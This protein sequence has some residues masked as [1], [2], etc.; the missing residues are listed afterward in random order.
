MVDESVAGRL[1]AWLHFLG[2]KK[3]NLKMKRVMKIVRNLIIASGLA[4]AAKEAYDW[5]QNG[6]ER[7]SNA[8]N[9]KFKGLKLDGFSF[10]NGGSVT[11]IPMV[12]ITNPL[13]TAVNGTVKSIDVLKNNRLLAKATPDDPAITLQPGVNV[14]DNFAFKGRVTPI[15]NNAL[16][17]DVITI[18]VQGAFTGVP[19]KRTMN[20]SQKQLISD[21]LFT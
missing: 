4:Y 12:E 10:G 8:L 1:G 3:I 6:S 5:Y 20:L 19:L 18:K 16:K 21:Y 2:Q 9:T 17:G 14:I 13:P 15:L 7:V 11:A